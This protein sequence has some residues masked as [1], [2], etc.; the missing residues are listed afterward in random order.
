MSGENLTRQE[1]EERSALIKTEHYRVE[2]DLSGSDEKVYWSGTTVTFS[3]N[4]TGS[5]TFIDAIAERITRIQLNGEDLDPAKV[6]DGYRIALS[7]LQPENS[8]IVE[9]FFRYTNTGVGMHRFVDPVDSNTYLYSHFEPADSRLMFTV[10]EQP[11]LKANF[12]FV[13]TAPAAWTVISNQPAA[14]VDDV[15]SGKRKWHFATTPRISSYITAVVAGPYHGIHGELTTSG[16]KSVPLG[17]YCRQ[18]LKDFV[19]AEYMMDVTTKGVKFYEEKFGVDFPFDKYDQIYTPEY[20]MGAMEN[21]GCVTYNEKYIFRSQ[22]PIALHERRVVT[23]LHELAHM[24]FGN[25]VTMKWWNDLWL[26]E[27]FAEYISHLATA[28][29]SEFTDAWTTFCAQEKLWAYGEDQLPTTHPIVDPINDLMDVEANFDGIT[30]AKGASSLQQLVAF[31]GQENFLAGVGNYFRKHSWG[32]TVLEDLLVELEASS[33][34][35]LRDWAAQWLETSGLNTLSPAVTI[36]GDGKILG[37]AVTQG[38]VKEYPTIRAHRIKVGFYNLQDSKVVRTKQFE[39]EI[40]SAV[41]QVP[42]AVGETRPDLIL[43]NDDDQSYAKVRLDRNSYEFARENLSKLEDPLARAQLWVSIWNT[44]RDAE[45][46]PSHFIDLVLDHIS[47]EN[48]SMLVTTMFNQLRA[49]ANYYLAPKG[50]N[51]R[52]AAVAERLWALAEKAEPASDMQLQLVLNFARLARTDA[53]AA[54]LQGLHDGSRKLE[55]LQL[56]ADLRWELL[57]GLATVGTI[58]RAVIDAE[59][60]KDNT[61]NGRAGAAAAIGALNTQDSKRDVWRKL[62]HNN[63][64]SNAEVMAAAYAF[65]RTT[66]PAMLDPFVEQYFDDV[67]YVYENKTYKMAEYILLGLFPIALAN[68]DLAN[69]TKRW[70]DRNAKANHTLRRLLKRNLGT[71]E[72]ALEAQGMDKGE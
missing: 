26:N 14:S 49:F 56:S 54:I 29:V 30:Y 58:D 43:L 17:V 4:R 31:V 60:A 66:T 42:E 18:S 5:K 68:K 9:G 3:A 48:Q 52:I 65:N 45:V 21:A 71:L 62:V 37:F 2:L 61:A 67:K 53:Q 25:L 11:D 59:L 50:R 13:V 64:W 70:L 47:T 44:A 28:E 10:F 20:N 32:N 8:L 38:A 34:R 69:Q 33:G 27:S 7:N 6:Y 16:G 19:E 1:A 51:D 63:D 57:T 55:G 46:V 35:Q 24:W 12:D 41:A 23:I 36:D 22:Q 40:D 15:G 39:V 72:R